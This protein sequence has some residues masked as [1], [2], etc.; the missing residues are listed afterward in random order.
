MVAVI[1]AKQRKILSCLF[2]NFSPHLAYANS[3]L[4][5]LLF[6]YKMQRDELSK[7]TA[8]AYDPGTVNTSLYKHANPFVAWFV[9]A[10]GNFLLR[11]SY[12]NSLF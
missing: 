11:V 4:A 10:F 2:S 1:I 7:L 5:L 3:K 9:R 12:A 6:T 8:I